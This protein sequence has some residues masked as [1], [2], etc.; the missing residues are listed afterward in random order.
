MQSKVKFSKF[1]SFIIVFVM[2]FTFMAGAIAAAEYPTWQ[3][4]TSYTVGEI[5]SYGSSNYK[6]VQAHTSLTGWEPPNVPALWNLY[7]GGGPIETVSS[8]TFNPSEGTYTYAQNVT[9]TC[10]TSDATIRYTLDGSEPIST[11][12]QYAG[13]INIASTT[14]VK[15]KAFKSGMNDSTTAHKQSY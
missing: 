4:G 12:T 13:A 9:L 15:A 7:S 1:I 3:A 10:T 6:C 2:V 8:P 5:V 11:S 14:T